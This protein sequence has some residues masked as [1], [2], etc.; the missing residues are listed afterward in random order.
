MEQVY[1]I[2]A[3]H[4]VTEK[5]DL[6]A[7][8]SELH[9]WAERFNVEFKLDVP[10]LSLCLDWLSPRCYG[11]FRPGFNGFGLHNEIAINRRYVA[12][13]EFW[14]TLRTLLHEMPHAWQHAFGLPSNWNHHNSEFRSKALTYGLIVDRHG[15]TSHHNDSPFTR[16][17]DKYGVRTPET[18]Q[19]A[20]RAAGTSKL[21][22]W[23]CGCTNVRVAVADFAAVCLHCRN[24]FA[25]V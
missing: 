19:P 21:R 18:P 16:L 10:H 22:K 3:Y 5:W 20:Q 15:V 25:P 9:P 14:E 8:A 17:L 12:V 11:H 13:R 23:S 7:L 24:R 1:P 6:Q 4:Q 2:L